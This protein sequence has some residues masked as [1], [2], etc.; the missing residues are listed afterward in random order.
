MKLSSIRFSDKILVF[1]GPAFVRNVAIP[2]GAIADE[3]S[4]AAIS[5]LSV[6]DDGM[7][8]VAE[9]LQA[10]LTA[11]GGLVVLGFIGTKL[12]DKAFDDLY[13]SLLRPAFLSAMAGVEYESGKYY[14]VSLCAIHAP[15]RRTILLV[16]LGECLE[17]ISSSELRI[18]TALYQGQIWA[19]AN[20]RALPVHLYRIK[21]GNVMPSP[22]LYE[23]VEVALK[24]LKNSIPV[25]RPRF[26]RPA[27]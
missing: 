2:L 12:A 10:S 6:V 1:G 15:T 5:D 20:P 19:E 14:A 26:V 9:Q 11:L 18:T 22:E 23:T 24:S 25:A 13:T 16:A 4:G 21:G 27:I 8:E 17:E 7:L 3:L